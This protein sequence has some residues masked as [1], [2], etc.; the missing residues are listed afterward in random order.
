M[1]MYKK[2][3][4]NNLLPTCCPSGS[5]PSPQDPMLRYPRLDQ[6]T[7]VLISALAASTLDLGGMGG[8]GSTQAANRGN[9]NATSL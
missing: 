3:F 4:R 1:N 8:E 2:H 7:W 9:V 5:P 6:K